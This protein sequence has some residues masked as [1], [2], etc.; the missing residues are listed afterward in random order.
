M[1]LDAGGRRCK[2]IVIHLRLKVT[3]LT[4]ESQQV[5]MAAVFTLHT[6][7]AVVQIAAIEAALDYL[8]DICPPEP[9]LT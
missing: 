9:L 8:F 2:G 4:G 6:G 5:F 3:P 7:K 1:A